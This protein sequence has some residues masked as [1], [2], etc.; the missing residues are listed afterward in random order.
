MPPPF[1]VTPI[2]VVPC[3]VYLPVM[4]VIGVVVG[5]RGVAPSEISAVKVIVEGTPL[6][7]AP[8]I[9]LISSAGVEAEKS[10]AKAGVLKERA[11]KRA[12]AETAARGASAEPHLPLNRIPEAALSKPGNFRH[13]V[14]LCILNPR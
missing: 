11:A 6:P 9:A 1:P 14:D 5:G 3:N 13:E 10:I 2:P 4:M 12:T 8:L 7:L